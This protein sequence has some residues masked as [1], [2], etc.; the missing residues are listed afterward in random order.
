MKKIIIFASCFFA[1]AYGTPDFSRYDEQF[2]SLS[3]K[4]VGLS[5][6]QIASLPN[7]FS[8]K[9]NNGIVKE[10]SQDEFIGKELTAIIA[11][12]VRINNEWYMLGEYIG[13]YE[14]VSIKDDSVII[15]NEKNSLELKLKKG[16]KNV[17]IQY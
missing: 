8:P 9:S 12:K 3:K 6:E 4:R 11:D 14:I 1:L 10:V 15:K 2:N 13:T 17:I 7:P 5:D 16:N